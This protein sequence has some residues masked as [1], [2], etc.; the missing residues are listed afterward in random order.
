[1]KIDLN[2]KLWKYYVESRAIVL[3]F[4]D[5]PYLRY[6]IDELSSPQKID[7]CSMARTMFIWAPIAVA[8]NVGAISL[9]A[10]SIFGLPYMWYGWY[11]FW[12]I[13]T[14]LLKFVALLATCVG[15]CYL[16]EKISARFSNRKNHATPGFL[17]TLYESWKGR[18]CTIVDVVETKPVT[19]EK[20]DVK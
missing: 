3:K 7:I 4:T 8:M 12:Y 13:F 11:G 16:Y 5:K 18:F 15:A 19:E 17:N 1:M 2:S 14:F 20:D 10:F 6:E 9:L